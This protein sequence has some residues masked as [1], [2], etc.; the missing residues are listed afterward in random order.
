MTCLKLVF[1]RRRS[2]YLKPGS[3]E[4]E[5]LYSDCGQNSNRVINARQKEDDENTQNRLSRKNIIKD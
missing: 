5:G 1:F 2:N 3:E 4:M